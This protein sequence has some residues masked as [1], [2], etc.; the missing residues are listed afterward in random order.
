LADLLRV[1]RPSIPTRVALAAE[2]PEQ[3][4]AF[5]AAAIAGRDNGPPGDRP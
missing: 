5:Y 2:R 3:V 1:G 4:D